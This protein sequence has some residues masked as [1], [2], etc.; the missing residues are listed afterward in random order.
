MC[1]CSGCFCMPINYDCLIK[2]RPKLGAINQNNIQA[3][4]NAT[5]YSYLLNLFGEKCI[6][7]FCSA[8]ATAKR[9]AV[10]A[11]EWIN[12]L[13]LKWQII[14]RSDYFKDAFA[15]AVY[16]E[17]LMESNYSMTNDGAV[18]IARD[19]KDISNHAD[20]Q[21]KHISETKRNAA[22]NHMKQFIS[23]ANSLV[24]KLITEN[25]NLYSDCMPAIC[26]CNDGCNSNSQIIKH[27]APRLTFTK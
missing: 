8:I 1:D 16:L 19:G 25:I 21:T 17:V 24:K 2:A 12:L 18:E 23:A 3:A 13:P 10:P 6:E 11:N 4:I 15:A 20:Y 22:I 7:D 14:C 9:D 26:G 5:K 27:K